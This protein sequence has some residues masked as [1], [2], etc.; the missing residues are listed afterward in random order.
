[1][2]DGGF[3]V[4]WL[5]IVSKGGGSTDYKYYSICRQYYSIRRP[6][7]GRGWHVQGKYK[8]LLKH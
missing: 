8:E 4:R 1:M 7:W 2:D 6:I 5:K 3:G